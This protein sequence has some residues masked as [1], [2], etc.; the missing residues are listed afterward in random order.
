[1]GNSISNN[2]SIMCDFCNQDTNKNLYLNL[3]C[4]QCKE[5]FKG[6][7]HNECVYNQQETAEFKEVLCPKCIS[8]K[9]KTFV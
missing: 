8:H 9:N 7:Y 5:R 4:P 2:Q 1:M 3:Q 6:Y